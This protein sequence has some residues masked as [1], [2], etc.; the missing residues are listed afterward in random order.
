MVNKLQYKQYKHNHL[1]ITHKLFKYK[2][3]YKQCNN[4]MYNK[5]KQYKYLICNNR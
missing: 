4:L 2:V 1:I 3:K 5:H